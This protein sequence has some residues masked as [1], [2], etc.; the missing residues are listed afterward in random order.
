[1]EGGETKNIE[2][3]YK[4]VQGWPRLPIFESHPAQRSFCL[5]NAS[6]RQLCLA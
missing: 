2:I 3:V 1:M 4:S 6:G 5:A